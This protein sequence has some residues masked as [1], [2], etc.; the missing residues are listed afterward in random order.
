LAGGHSAEPSL[1]TGAA[2]EIAAGRSVMRIAQ[3]RTLA[4]QIKQITA[5]AAKVINM[6]PATTST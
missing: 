5:H 4:G 6:K 1:A 3:L 2:L